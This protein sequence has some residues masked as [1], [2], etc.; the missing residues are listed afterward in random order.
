MNIIFMGTP[1]FAVPCLARLIEEKYNIVGVFTQPDKPKGRGHKLAFSPVKELAIENEI[2]VFQ[3]KSLK[4]DE[5]LEQIKSLN[6][7]LIVVVAYGK[8]LPK[9]VLDLPQYGCINVHGSLLPKY[10]GAAPIQWSV[11]NGETKTGVTTMFM[12]EGIDTGDMLLKSETAIGENETAS[13]LYDRLAPLGADILSDT[14]IALKE[15]RLNPIRQD[16]KEATHAPMLYKEMSNIDFSKDAKDLHNL[17]RGLSDWPCAITCLQGKRLK[18][19]KSEVVSMDKNAQCGSIV[20]NKN[21]IVACGN[22]T[23]IKLV[24]VQ[25]DN[26]KRMGGADF[27]RGKQVPVGEILTKLEG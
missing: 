14:L 18:V 16:D 26:S 25:Y 5:A 10:R 3:P 4:N 11:L 7:D 17:I 13:E 1:D 23:A 20:D 6:P 8:I 9:V 22:D 27:L 2:K 21:F 12:G 15:G 24:S 19:Y